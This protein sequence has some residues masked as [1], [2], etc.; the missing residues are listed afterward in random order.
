M[1]CRYALI[2]RKTARSQFLSVN[3]PLCRYVL[4]CLLHKHVIYNTTNSLVQK[5][6][7]HTYLNK[8]WMLHITAVHNRLQLLHNC[9]HKQSCWKLCIYNDVIK[10]DSLNKSS[11]ETKPLHVCLSGIQSINPSPS[12]G[13]NTN[14]LQLHTHGPTQT[15]KWSIYFCHSWQHRCPLSLPWDLE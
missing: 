11:E 12:L 5:K 4:K 14:K 10:K 6:C 1:H 15:P 9:H 3:G 13:L 8:A 7:M 2:A